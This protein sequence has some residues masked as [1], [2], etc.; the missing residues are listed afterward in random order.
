MYSKTELQLVN[1]GHHSKCNAALL[2][3]R[4]WPKKKRQK[5]ISD[6]PYFKYLFSVLSAGLQIPV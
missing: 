6:S 2:R 3:I 1:N 5:S 4:D